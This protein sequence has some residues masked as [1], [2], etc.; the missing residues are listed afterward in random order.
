MTH[1][2]EKELEL[3]K[4]AAR[5]AG[6]YLIKR[7][8][9]HVDANVGK[10]IK[11]SSDK[12]S[13][14]LII[15]ILKVSGIPILSEECG[16]VDVHAGPAGSDTVWIIDPLDG[17]ANYWK[18]LQELSCVS[19]A[20]WKG[21]APVL[22]VVYRFFCNELYYGI[23]GQGAFLNGVPIRTSDVTKTEQAVVATG[24]PVHRDYGTE[25]LSAF[26]RQVQRFKKVRMLGAAAVMGTF[27]AAGKVDA[28]MEDEIMLWDV[29]GASALVLAAG[30]EVSVELLEDDKCIC[31]CFATRALMEDYYAKSL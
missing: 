12:Y 6:S 5:E 15:D 24:F 25:S 13:E 20:L 18:G 30:G 14:E 27:V 28:Y 23:V 10:D 3:A 31:K 19:I 17:T 21:D 11:L 8:E 29:A 16:R 7:E 4:L 22:G 9:I 26:V 1:M 2:Y